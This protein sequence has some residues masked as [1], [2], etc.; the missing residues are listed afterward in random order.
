[1]KVGDLVR[2]TKASPTGRQPPIGIVL[3]LPRSTSDLGCV[4]VWY[5]GKVRTW[6]YRTCEVLNESG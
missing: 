4:K 3:A 6:A 1:M 2:Y 5:D